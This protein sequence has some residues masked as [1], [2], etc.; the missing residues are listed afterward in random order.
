MSANAPQKAASFVP[1]SDMPALTSLRFLAAAIVFL[2]HF[3]PSGAPWPL[4]V[5]AAQ[6]HVG[7][8]VFFVLSGFLITARY[9]ETLRQGPDAVTLNQYFRKRFARIVPLY[10]TV[11]GLS[12]VLATDRPAFSWQ[13]LPE[14]LLLQGFLSRSVDDLAVPTSWTLTLEECF[15]ALAPLIFLGVRRA[16]AHGALVLLAWT[17]GLLGVGVALLQVVDAERFQF[18]GSA[19]EMLRHTFFGRFV[20]FALGVWGGRLYLSGAVSRTWARPGGRFAAT[21]VGIA[22]IALI[23]AG[24][25]GMTLAGGLDTEHWRIAWSF[26]LVVGCGSLVLILALT[27]SASVLSRA[28]ALPPFVYLGRVSYAMY[29]IQLTPLG[30]GFLYRVIPQGAPGFG[31]LLYAGMT[32]V[33][34]ILFEWVEEP[35]RRLVM[36]L[37]PAERSPDPPSATRA[38]PRTSPAWAIVSLVA[39]CA[40]VQATAWADSRLAARRGPPTVHEAQQVASSMPDRIVAVPSSTLLSQATPDGSRHRVP[41]PDSWM[42]GTES[43]RRAPPSLLVFADGRS[44]PFERRASDLDPSLAGAHYRGPRTS[45]VELWLPSGAPPSQVTLVRHDPPLALGLL[46]GRLASSPPL[47]AVIACVVAGAAAAA[48]LYHARRRPR[49]GSAA[50]ILCAVSAFFL[51]AEV[52]ERAWAPLVIGAELLA[53]SALAWARRSPRASA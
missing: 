50:P 4:A 5:V 3:P 2:H 53:L 15:Y 39:A 28:L 34:A 10:W 35:A 30:K 16:R 42:I 12:L 43:D 14:W 49:L 26:N 22:G 52:H 21:A 20:D 32:L 11:L 48:W 51:L 23:F 24:Q 45:F 25:A 1:D 38:R 31:L 37:W 17:A 36:R 9:S 7:V 29:L 6:G 33:S 19:S 18:L 47:L 13:V 40:L 44:V 41:I 27:S 8:T 46:A